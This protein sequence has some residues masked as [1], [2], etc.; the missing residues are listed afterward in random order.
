MRV[1]GRLS[2]ALCLASTASL[3]QISVRDSPVVPLEADCP[4]GIRATVEK[5]EKPLAAQR[6]QVTLIQWPPLGVV[7]SR[8]T[9][10]GI[11][12]VV[13]RPKPSEITESL[14]LNRIVDHPTPSSISNVSNT[15]AARKETPAGQGPLAELNDILGPR[16]KPVLIRRSSPDSRWYAWVTGFDAV[17]SIDLESVSYADGTSW[18]V[19][20][21]KT[22]RV[23]T[24]SSVW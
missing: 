2:F 9:I 17:N 8:I 10:H 7:A 13:N 22:C 24:A 6:L 15:S 21:G 12:A 4:I 3:G 20:N 5:N 19:S 1:A 18:H 14:D 11:A 16:T 23:S